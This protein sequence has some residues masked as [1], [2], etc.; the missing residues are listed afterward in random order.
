MPD[1]YLMFLNYLTIIKANVFIPRAY[2]TLAD[3]G[4]SGIF[5]LEDLKNI[6][7]SNLFFR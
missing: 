3:F 7:F 6:R 2:A 5:G 4:F 1:W